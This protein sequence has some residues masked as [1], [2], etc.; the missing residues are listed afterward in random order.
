MEE[1]EEEFSLEFIKSK[2]GEDATLDEYKDDISKEDY[3]GIMLKAAAAHSAASIAAAAPAR[4]PLSRSGGGSGSGKKS[5]KTET[6]PITFLTV[7]GAKFIEKWKKNRLD[8]ADKCTTDPDY[9]D[10]VIPDEHQPLT[11]TQEDANDINSIYCM[12]RLHTTYQGPNR[13]LLNKT[14]EKLTPMMKSKS[15]AH[16]HAGSMGVINPNKYAASS[17]PY[18]FLTTLQHFLRTVSHF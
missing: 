18:E 5:G 13:K 15:T 1:Y 9:W 8:A 16:D 4:S 14:L 17:L 7:P 2:H 10:L 12:T 3:R 11:P 6:L